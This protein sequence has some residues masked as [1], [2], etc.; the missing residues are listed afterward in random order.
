M[1]ISAQ[2]RTAVSESGAALEIQ[3]SVVC[4]EHRLVLRGELDLAQSAELE[5]LL[6]QVCSNGTRAITLDLSG[7]TFMG[8]TGLRLVLLARDLCLQRAC[9]FRVVPGP[10]N[11]QRVFDVTGLA[12][13]I[14]FRA[15]P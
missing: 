2:S 6:R 3:D 10:A 5:A 14:P 8:S 13:V 12:A 15:A 9:E 11:V 1:S 4:G 7:L